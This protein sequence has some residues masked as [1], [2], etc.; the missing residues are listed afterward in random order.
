VAKQLANT[1]KEKLRGK[2]VLHTSG[3]LDRSV[4]APLA[5]MGAATGSMH[6]MQ[7]FSSKRVP[8]LDRNIFAV[9]GDARARQVARVMARS[10]GGIP[11]DIE[12]EDKPDYHA[13][14]V[15]AAGHALALIESATQILMRT[16]FSRRRA[17]QTLLPL[18]RQML[19]NFESA[20]PQ[21]AWTGPVARG[22]YGVVAKHMRALKKFPPEFA[23]AYAA[24]ARLAPRVLARD[25]EAKLR[26]L[27]RALQSSRRGKI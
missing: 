14:G 20:G 4:L 6:P 27:H 22:D 9:E 12:S 13:A 7:T 18:M 24:L 19:D 3:A 23:K 11:I 8:N 15:L 5:R 17:Q 1:G 16:G 25:P 10:L 26:E 2:V 21:A